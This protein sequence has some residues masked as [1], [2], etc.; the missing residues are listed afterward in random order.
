MQKQV[1]LVLFPK[2]IFYATVYHH[3]YSVRVIP[4]TIIPHLDYGSSLLL[5]QLCFAPLLSLETESDHIE[6]F[7]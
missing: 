7:F 4:A 6:T 3:L 2:L 5:Y 1:L